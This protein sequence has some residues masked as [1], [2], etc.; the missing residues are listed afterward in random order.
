MAGESNRVSCAQ[1]G[2]ASATYLC[3]H[4][5]EDPVQRWYCDYPTEDRPWPDAWCSACEAVYAREGGWNETSKKGVP[6]RLLCCH[7]YEHLRSGS[8][9][10]LDEDALPTWEAFLADCGNGLHRKQELLKAE[11][12]LDTHKRYHWDQ[13]TGELIFSNDGVPAVVA[14][15]QFVGSISTVSHTWL[16]SWA[17]FD[18]LEN[19]R[20]RVIAVRKLGERK[21]F[22]RLTVPKWRAEK[23]GGWEMSAVAAHVLD[24]RGVFCSPGEGFY[25]FMVMTDVRRLQ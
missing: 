10:R 25:G 11:F 21:G 6:I 7:C 14:T 22:P 1:H 17:N 15:I 3:Q 16:W 13:A 12:S 20:T 5:V 9:D 19:V 8:V 24:A 2:K 4:L 23:A 18:L